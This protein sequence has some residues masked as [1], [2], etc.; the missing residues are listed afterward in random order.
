MGARDCL[1]EQDILAGM[2]T[3]EPLSPTEEVLW[4]A[5]MRIVKVIPRH[6]DTDLTRGAG[7]DGERIHDNHAPVRSPESR[8]ADG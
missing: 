4:R 7:P 5:V 2:A 3:V 6:L 1:V 8:A